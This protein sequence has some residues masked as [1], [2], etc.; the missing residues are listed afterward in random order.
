M[1]RSRNASSMVDMGRVRACGSPSKNTVPVAVAATGGTKRITVPA[2]PQLMVPPRRGRGS[3]WISDPWS[4]TPTPMLFN[5]ASMRLVS[6]LRSA[7]TIADGPSASAARM[8]ARLVMDLEPG[9]VITPSMGVR[10]CGAS[11]TGSVSELN[12]STPT[13]LLLLIDA[14]L[15]TAPELPAV[16]NVG[17]CG[18]LQWDKCP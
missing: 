12:S 9:T 4:R 3:M 6:R 2:S 16:H 1:P 5:A 14:V 18:P 11:H 7:P 10:V 17:I 15:V 13:I 8:N